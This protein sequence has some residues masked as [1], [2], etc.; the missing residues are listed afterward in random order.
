MVSNAKS[1][2]KP[3]SPSKKHPKPRLVA[4]GPGKMSS[5]ADVTVENVYPRR[6]N[7]DKTIA[8]ITFG[9]TLAINTLTVGYTFGVITTRVNIAEQQ[10]TEIRGNLRDIGLLAKDIA[11]VKNQV[12]SVVNSVQRLERMVL[13]PSNRRGSGSFSPPGMANQPTPRD[14]F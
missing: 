14:S 10:I 1:K 11:V 5:H 8:W 13:E 2:K 6:I 7:G 3:V 4:R 9:V 12:D